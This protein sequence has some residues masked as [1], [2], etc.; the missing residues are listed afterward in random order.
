MIKKHHVI[1]YYLL[2]SFAGHSV[3]LS[4][5]GGK[6]VVGDSHS[7]GSVVLHLGDALTF[8]GSVHSGMT[9]NWPK[10]NPADMWKNWE[11]EEL[12]LSPI[13]Q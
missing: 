11:L 2:V 7:V 5:A 12:L 9:Q 8:T 6:W 3:F 13:I 10:S 4:H 1:S